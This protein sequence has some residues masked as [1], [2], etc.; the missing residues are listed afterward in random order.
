MNDLLTA[1][2]FL[3][4]AEKQK[5][6]MSYKTLRLYIDLGLIRKPEKRGR[7]VGFYHVEGLKAVKTIKTLIQNYN[8]KLQQI[9]ELVEGGVELQQILDIFKGSSKCKEQVL[10]YINLGLGIDEIDV[11]IKG[12]GRGLDLLDIN[13]LLKQFSKRKYNMFALEGE[14]GRLINQVKERSERKVKVLE[15]IGKRIAEVQKRNK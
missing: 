1:E 6:P 3:K 2:E 11:L 5:T 10:A 7:Y 9:K 15:D 8:L 13:S 14:I 12:S 4:E